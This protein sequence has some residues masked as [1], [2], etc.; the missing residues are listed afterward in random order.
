VVVELPLWRQP[1]NLAIA[2]DLGKQ[3]G[4]VVLALLILTMLI[5]PALKA[6]SRPAPA[7]K[8]GLMARM[9]EELE[10]PGPATSAR[11][12]NELKMPEGHIG[13]GMT[14]EQT[15]ALELA[16]S[17]PNA[18]ATVVKAWINRDRPAGA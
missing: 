5:R 13:M 11:I 8:P 17:D 15:S 2:K 1:E 3:L 9:D 4:F 12:S 14:S 18:V 7:S 16:R 10:L 6:A